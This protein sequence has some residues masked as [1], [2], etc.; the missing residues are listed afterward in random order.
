MTARAICSVAVLVYPETSLSCRDSLQLQI[1]GVFVDAKRRG[2]TE[3]DSLPGMWS[4]R[5]VVFETPIEIT[6]DSLRV[7]VEPSMGET[8]AGVLVDAFKKQQRVPTPH[9]NHPLL[10]DGKPTNEYY[11]WFVHHMGG[12]FMLRDLDNIRNC[13]EVMNGVVDTGES[14]PHPLYP[15]CKCVVIGIDAPITIVFRLC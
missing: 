5:R 14:L 2:E 12:A 11:S 9:P 7:L 8:S 13:V 3:L 1:N 10:R 4:G 6:A 15:D